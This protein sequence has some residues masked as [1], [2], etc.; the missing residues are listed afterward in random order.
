MNSL[1]EEYMRSVLGF[2]TQNTYNIDFANHI[3]YVNTED[4]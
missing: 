3:S 4:R 2:D 1:Y